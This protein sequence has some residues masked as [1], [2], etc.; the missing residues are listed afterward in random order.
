MY[1]GSFYVSSSWL[2]SV[3]HKNLP[4]R[5]PNAICSISATW[6]A[7]YKFFYWTLHLFCVYWRCTPFIRTAT[8]R[9][10]G[11]TKNKKRRQMHRCEN[12]TSRRQ[13]REDATSPSWSYRTTSTVGIQPVRVEMKLKS[14]N[15][16]PFWNTALQGQDGQSNKSTHLPFTLWKWWG[17][18]CTLVFNAS[19]TRSSL[20]EW[21]QRFQRL[22]VADPR[23]PSSYM[24]QTSNQVQRERVP[25]VLGGDR[26]LIFNRRPEQTPWS[27]Y[28]KLSVW[29]MNNKLG[30]RLLC[31]LSR[32]KLLCLD[33][34]WTVR[35]PP[36]LTR[37][38]SLSQACA[39]PVCPPV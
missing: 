25:G 13:A 37:H 19:F 27:R 38:S 29:V 1:R 4:P 5:L 20:I 26:H 2:K 35:Q 24:T 39:T 21:L 16:P 34:R 18:Y 9:L 11:E 30:G 33:L 8:A 14:P 15:S 12:K 3:R 32:I 10:R 36:A 23:A 22:R 28:D 6:P 31:F 7:A 17:F